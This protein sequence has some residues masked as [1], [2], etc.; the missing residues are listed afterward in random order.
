MRK[1]GNIFLGCFFENKVVGW[2]QYREGGV[3]KRGGLFLRE[4]VSSGV[5][6]YVLV[7]S[8]RRYVGG[9]GV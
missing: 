8:C 2:N 6:S 4:Y 3:L 9:N 5:L 1:K 7:M